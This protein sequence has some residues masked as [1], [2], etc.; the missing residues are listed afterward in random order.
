MMG[1]ITLDEWFDQNPDAMQEYYSQYEVIDDSPTT[2]SNR[3]RILTAETAPIF[4]NL[5]GNIFNGFNFRRQQNKVAIA[6]AQAQAAQAQAENKSIDDTQ[7]TYIA[8]AVAVIVI[9]VLLLKK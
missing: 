2:G 5:V 7:L 9:I 3:K 8:I 1:P 4:A 6:Q